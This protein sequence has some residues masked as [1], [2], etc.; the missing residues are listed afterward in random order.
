MLLA[1]ALA[2]TSVLSPHHSHQGQVTR[3]HYVTGGWSLTVDHD[4]FTDALTCSLKTR[5]MY[6]RNRTLIFH[7]KN[8]LETTHAFYRLDDRPAAPVSKAFHDVETLGFFPRRGWVDNPAGGD[9]ALPVSYLRDTGQVAI[10]ASTRM[11]PTVFKVNRLDDA[12]GNARAQ[13]CT[14]AAFQSA[15]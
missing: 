13:G 3:Y 1:A 4:R 9:V 14:E 10:R 8:G 12:L 7:L 2:L 15:S 6:Y 5:T 11:A